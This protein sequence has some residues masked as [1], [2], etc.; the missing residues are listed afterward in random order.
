MTAAFPPRNA[1]YPAD[2]IEEDQMVRT[3]DWVAAAGRLLIAG[4]FLVSGIGKILSPTTT[5]AYIA[6][7]G[8]PFPV[9]GYLIAIAIE[10]GGTIL[11]VTGFQ[12]R[13]TALVMA[14]FSIIT[15]LC[16]HGNI[17]DLAQRI[18]LLKDISIAGGLL[19][20]VA[21]GPGRLSIDNW[22]LRRAE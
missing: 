12:S 11:L 7:A 1:V 15:G 18:Q 16:F 9:L 22:R 8:L 21:F 3:V 4:L 5:Q 14:I 19:Q 13:K 6:A 20:I 10:I 17:A 2:A